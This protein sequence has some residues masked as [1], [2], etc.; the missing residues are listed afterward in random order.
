MLGTVEILDSTLREGEQFADACFSSEDR[1]NLAKRLDAFGVHYIE[2]SSPVVSARAADD[3]RN[4]AALNMKAR[5]M[6]H[7]RCEENEVR[8]ALE[9]GAQGINLYQGSSTV[10]RY[11]S[12]GRSIEEIVGNAVS[13]VRMLKSNGVFVRFS[14]EDAFRTSTDDL[15]RVLDPIVA[16]GV[17]RIGL[18]D[19]VGIATPTAVRDRVAFFQQRYSI[20]MEFH[21]HN[22]A[23]CAV[24]NALA[25]IEGGADVIDTTVLGIGERNGIVSLSGLIARLYT[26]DRSS[27]QQYKLDLLPGLDALVSSLASVPIPF[28]SPI[29]GRT[30]FTHKAGVHT[31]AVLRS[32]ETYEIIDPSDFGVERH[33]QVASRVTGKAAIRYRAQQLGLS[34]DDQNLREATA[35]IKSLADERP[36][37]MD[38]VDSVLN[39]YAAAV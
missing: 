26:L 10:M 9:C 35:R 12:H 20:S 18:P 7:C 4:L 39:L 23:G 16:A 21:G 28:N 32:P 2:V 22:D 33:I 36:I 25:A 8:A 19:T 17:D 13:L 31:N 14:A 38:D 29:T 24:A 1:L 11:Y 15:T 5:I 6:A 34:L 3:I 27:V 37:N 30:A